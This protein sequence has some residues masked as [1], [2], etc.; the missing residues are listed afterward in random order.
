VFRRYSSDELAYLKDNYPIFLIGP[1][2]ELFNDKFN[3]SRS[4]GQIKSCL[5]NHRFKSGRSTGANKGVSKIFTAEQFQFIRDNYSSVTA[6]EMVGVLADKF[7]ISVTYQQVK[8]FVK[9]HGIISGRTGRFEKGQDSWNA[10]TKGVMKSNSG[11]FM[12]GRPAP[13][14]NPFGHE[15]T[16][17]DGCVLIKV[18]QVNPYTGLNGFYKAKHHVSYESKYGP[19][20]DGHVVRFIDGDRLNFEPE[21]LW[22]IS[23]ALNLRLN[24]LGYMGLPEEIKPT[25]LAVAELEIKAFAMAKE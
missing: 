21:N 9:N 12:K 1:L 11:S 25:A 2:T 20:P 18:D 16:D 24:Q 5:K 7:Y 17:R 10:G 4:P 13:N 8:T 14:A 15:R 22:A 6:K 3:D 23:K 19:V